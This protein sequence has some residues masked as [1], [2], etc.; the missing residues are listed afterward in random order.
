MPS[1]V[2]KKY[3]NLMTTQGHELT[4]ITQEHDFVYWSRRIQSSD[5]RAFSELFEAMHPVLL[6]YAW[7]FANN[8][9]TA[10]DIVQDAFLKLWQIRVTVDPKRS[11]KALLY[12]MVRNLALNHIRNAHHEAG[13]LPEQGPLDDSPAP[14]ELMDA[15][16]LDVRLARYIRELPERRRE[17]FMLSRFEGLSHGEIAQV[18][19]LTPRTVNTHIVLALRDLRHRL[20]MLQT[21][22]SHATQNR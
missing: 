21:L 13:T 10:Q 4:P 17:A 19:K 1:G 2:L 20:H 18:M 6:R 12:T 9:E 22:P 15:A 5:Q 16:M 8:N 14:D 11:L 7:R 3:S